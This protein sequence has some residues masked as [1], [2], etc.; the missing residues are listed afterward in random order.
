MIINN[1]LK[2]DTPLY[3]P[4]NNKGNLLLFPIKL[5]TSKQLRE[6]KTPNQ[7]LGFFILLDL[8]IYF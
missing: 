7:S 5:T 6:I 8:D 1:F 4:F 3:F 2:I